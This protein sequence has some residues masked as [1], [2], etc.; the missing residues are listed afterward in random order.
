MDSKELGRFGEA[1]AVK[2]LKAQGY[3]IVTVNYRSVLGEIDVICRK[4]DELVF[5]EVKTRASTYFGEPYESVTIAKQRKLRKLAEAYIAKQRL[6]DN[7]LR[8]DV[9]SIIVKGSTEPEITWIKY[10]F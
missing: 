7:K 6:S 4:A 2:Y 9:I 5:V 3:K 1:L 10:A 8:F